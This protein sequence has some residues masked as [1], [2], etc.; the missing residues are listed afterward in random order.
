MKITLMPNEGIGYIATNGHMRNNGE[1]KVAGYSVSAEEA[2]TMAQ[3]A[4]AKQVLGS[5][6]K[7][8]V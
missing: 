4:D 6:R 8:N 3:C 5:V 1:K 2:S 7:M